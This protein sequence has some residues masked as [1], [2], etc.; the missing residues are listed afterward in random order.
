MQLLGTDLNHLLRKCNKKFT[1][2]TVL[3]LA[4][5]MIETIKFIHSKEYMH[6]DIAPRN[7]MMG[8]GSEKGKLFF[9]DFGI[10]RKFSDDQGKHYEYK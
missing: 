6:C 2:K 7:I 3:M 5:Q 4:D 10:C 1:L 9:M 8:T